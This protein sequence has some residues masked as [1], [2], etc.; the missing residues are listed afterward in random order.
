MRTKTVLR[1]CLP[2]FL[3]MLL[4][5]AL[6]IAQVTGD[7]G[8]YQILQARYGTERRNVD[9]TPRLKEL[10]RQGRSFRMDN[11]TFGIDPDYGVQ[12][13]LRIYA[14]DQRGRDRMFE[15]I[16]GSTVDGSVFSGW[17]RGNWGQARWDGGWNGRN[18][19]T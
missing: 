8:Q 13:V 11:A 6:S 10:A 16:E 18:T 1:M 9:V 5:S 7:S 15:Y 4:S 19:N 2:A 14:Q 3:L 17:S 12:K